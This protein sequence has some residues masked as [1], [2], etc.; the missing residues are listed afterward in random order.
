MSGP[1]G[2]RPARLTDLPEL[3]DLERAFPGDRIAASSFRR[4]L[5]RPSAE[6]WVL[7]EGG[8]VLADLVLLFRRGSGVARVYSV[9]VDAALRGRGI[10]AHLYAHAADR[11]RARGCHAIRLEVRLDNPAGQA[12]A[13]AAGFRDAGVIPEFYED[14]ADALRMSL[15]LRPPT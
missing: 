9:V 1:P 5:R 14:G 15:D 11:A 10:G 8:R 13:R 3:L 2:L 7:D 6:L 4:L 12:L